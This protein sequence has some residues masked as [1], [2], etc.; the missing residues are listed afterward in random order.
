M[1]YKELKQMSKLKNPRPK[2]IPKLFHQEPIDYGLVDIEEIERLVQMKYR[3]LSSYYYEL[4]DPKNTVPNKDRILHSLNA[5]IFA[6]ERIKQMEKIK[7]LCKMLDEYEE[8]INSLVAILKNK[9]K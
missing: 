7:Y 1:R 5:L 8:L 9:N 2:L 3:D 6:E 4:K